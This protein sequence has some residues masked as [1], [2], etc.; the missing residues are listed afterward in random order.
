MGLRKKKGSKRENRK[1]APENTSRFTKCRHLQGRAMRKA[2]TPMLDSFFWEK[3]R[4]IKPHELTPGQRRDWTERRRHSGL[5]HTEQV[6]GC[7]VS[8]NM[9]WAPRQRGDTWD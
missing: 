1:G 7:L 5:D 9:Q 2:W 6:T 4:S 8:K 3:N